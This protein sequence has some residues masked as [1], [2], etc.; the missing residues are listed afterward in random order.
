MC[1]D[2]PVYCMCVTVVLSA[3]WLWDFLHSHLPVLF[4]VHLCVTFV[5]PGQTVLCR[6]GTEC[7]LDIGCY[8]QRGSWLEIPYCLWSEISNWSYCIRVQSLLVFKVPLNQLVYCVTVWVAVTSSCSTVCVFICECVAT[9]L[10]VFS[11]LLIRQVYDTL[12]CYCT[13]NEPVFSCFLQ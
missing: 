7:W 12:I 3:L 4:T 6:L 9:C 2:V 1:I 13:P 11:Y 8:R 10:S 5:T